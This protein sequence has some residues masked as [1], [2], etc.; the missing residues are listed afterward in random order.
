MSTVV[1]ISGQLGGN[2]AAFR[3][4]P[5]GY[6]EYAFPWGQ[7]RHGAGPRDRPGTLAVR[8]PAEAGR[9]ADDARRSDADRR[10]LGPRHRQVGAGRLDHPVGA[11]DPARH[12]RHRHGQHRGPA[13]HQD[14]A[15][16]RQVAGAAASTG[17]G[18][19]TPRPR[20]QSSQREHEKTWRVDAITWSENNTEAIAGL[21]NKGKRAFALFDEASAIPDAGVGNDRGRAD[22]CGHRTVLGRLRQSDAHHR[23]LSRMLRRRPL[24]PSLAAAADRFALACR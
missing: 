1:D 6:V 3:R 5:L 13:P 8:H 9:G 7:A 22:R 15:R 14:L 24:R 17:T 12:A 19:P 21:H 20:S 23:P 11:V 18:S 2:V 16:A 10:R 4:H